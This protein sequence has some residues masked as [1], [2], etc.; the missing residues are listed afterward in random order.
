MA[1]SSGMQPGTAVPISPG[2]G[3]IRIVSNQQ[4]V[5]KEKA[6]ERQASSQ[7]SDLPMSQLAQH[8]RARMTDMRNFRIAEGIT[9]RLLSALRTYKGMYDVNKM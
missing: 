1:I 3:L 2:G 4:L 7:S 5:E 8:I 9:E 6:A